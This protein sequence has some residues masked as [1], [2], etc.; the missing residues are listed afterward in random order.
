MAEHNRSTV[1]VCLL[2]EQH[3]SETVSTVEQAIAED[4]HED[5]HDSVCDA[6]ETLMDTIRWRDHIDFN[7]KHTFG[8]D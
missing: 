5:I 3:F 1:E 2:L 4:A 7:T 6:L 8:V